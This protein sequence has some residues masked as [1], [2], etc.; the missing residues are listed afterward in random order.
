MIEEQLSD[1]P[2]KRP[3]EEINSLVDCSKVEAEL[4]WRQPRTLE[5]SLEAY[6]RLAEVAPY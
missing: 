4:G 6:G 2:F 1:I 3:F 5:E